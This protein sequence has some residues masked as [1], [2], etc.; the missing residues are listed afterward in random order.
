MKRKDAFRKV[1]TVCQRLDEADPETFFVIPKKLYLFGSLLTD[2]PNPSDVDL[3]FDYQDQ[4]NLDPNDLLYRL[5]YG[6]PLP[7]E[8]AIIH[9]RRRMK[10]IRIE[11]IEGLSLKRWRFVHGF[12]PNTPIKLVWEP[13]LDW[14]PIIDDLEAN[15]LPWQPEVEERNKQIQETLRHILETQG[16]LAAT[17]WLKENVIDKLPPE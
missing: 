13:G 9:L 10:M 2:K 6:K 4:P 17:Q 8:K 12:L 5:S 1:R 3:L 16:E 14:P 15:P 11:L 7:Y